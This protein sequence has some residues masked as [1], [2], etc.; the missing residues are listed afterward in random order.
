MRLCSHA[1]EINRNLSHRILEM[2]PGS[3]P[4]T[5]TL[6]RDFAPL[7]GTRGKLLVRRLDTSVTVACTDRAAD[8]AILVLGASLHLGGTA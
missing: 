1:H 4:T 8:M 2:G 3:V 5:P 6:T 7:T